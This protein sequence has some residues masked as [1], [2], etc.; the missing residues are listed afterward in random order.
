MLRV[1][2]TTEPAFMQNGY[3]IH[4]DGAAECWIIDPGLPP[5]AQQ[6]TQYARANELIPMAIILTHAHPDHFAG[7]DAMRALYP[8]AAVYLAAE[9]WHFLSD[10]L[11][12][13]SAGMGMPLTASTQSLLDLKDG[14]TLRLGVMEWQ[15]LDTSGH[16]PGG[17]SLYC[18]AEKTVVV[19]D[20]LFAGSIGRT[21]FPHSDHRRLIRNIRTRLFVLPEDTRVL[22]GHGPPTTIG[23]ERRSNPFVS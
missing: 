16:S 5:Q 13:L 15:V 19:G 17:R 14:M 11:A 12:N 2:C 3:V 4:A 9:E 8:K 20:A 6:M 7:L 22:C 23:E 1:H 10:P 18:A 21:D